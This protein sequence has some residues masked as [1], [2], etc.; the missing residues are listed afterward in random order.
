MCWLKRQTE[1]EREGIGKV[2]DVEEDVM[3]EKWTEREEE[4]NKQRK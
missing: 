1:R 4:R 3:I 2:R